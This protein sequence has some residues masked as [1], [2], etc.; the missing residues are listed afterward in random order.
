MLSELTPLEL[1]NARVERAGSTTRLVIANTGERGY[2]DAQLF[3]YAGRRRSEFTCRAPLRMTV[4]AWASHDA[5]SLRGTMGFGFWNQPIMPGQAL[6]RLPRAI[7]FF[8]GSRPSNM[9]LAMDVPGHGWK[10]A[11]LDATRL[12][13]LLLLPGAPLGFLL[14]RRPAMYRRLWPLAQWAVGVSE[15]LIDI[16][17]RSPH[18]YQL[19]WLPNAARFY[20]DDEMILQSPYA[21]RGSLGFVTWIDNQYA[22]VTPQGQIGM[23]LMAIPGEQWLALEDLRVEALK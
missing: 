18:R 19:D 10:A 13:F 21:P 5:D 2:S 6:P 17:L 12:P 14:M 4:R 16:D 9:A 23:G 11:V 8:F 1:G 15:K 22:V 7:W 3:D 20:V